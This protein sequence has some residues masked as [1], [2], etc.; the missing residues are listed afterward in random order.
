MYIVGVVTA[1]ATFWFAIDFPFT[2]DVKGFFFDT[3]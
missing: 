3:S 2:S 1:V